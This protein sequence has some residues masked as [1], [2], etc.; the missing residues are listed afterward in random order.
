MPA[1]K[2][3]KTVAKKDS[4]EKHPENQEGKEHENSEKL[5][6]V[7]G[8]LW[9]FAFI[10]SGLSPVV[11]IIQLILNPDL[12]TIMLNAFLIAAYLFVGISIFLKKRRAIIWAKQ[13]L[14]AVLVY[15]ILNII[16]AVAVGDLGSAST[17]GIIFFVIWFSYLKTSRRVK[18]TFAEQSLKK[19]DVAWA[20]AAPIIVYLAVI[21][22]YVLYLIA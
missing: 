15:S 16:I 7:R 20:I 18:N 13:M 10:L 6:G 11:V 22:I 1:R 8:W 12:L 14:I 2:E 4:K 3:P 21:I 5:Q 17:S 9:F 19:K